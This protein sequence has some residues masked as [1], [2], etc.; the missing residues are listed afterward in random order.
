MLFFRCVLF[1]PCVIQVLGQCFNG[2]IAR[3]NHVTFCFHGGRPPSR[4]TSRHVA[5]EGC[6][7]LPT[8]TKKKAATGRER[9][10]LWKGF[11]KKS[12]GP[13]PS[14]NKSISHQKG[15][16]E[17]HRIKRIMME[18]SSRLPMQTGRRSRY[19]VFEAHAY[20]DLDLYIYIYSIYKSAGA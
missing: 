7:T 17:N 13:N 2:C 11:L 4:T 8:V 15:S 9:P 6:G 3:Q 10:S 19:T 5:P 12:Q 18:G 14:G 16:L 1:S 20:L